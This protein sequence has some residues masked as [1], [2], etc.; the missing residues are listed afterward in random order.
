MV[1]VAARREPR[2]KQKY[3]ELLWGFWSLYIAYPDGKKEYFANDKWRESKGP[4]Q[5]LQKFICEIKGE[6]E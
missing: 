1:N 5:F 6:N 3:P 4:R 2:K